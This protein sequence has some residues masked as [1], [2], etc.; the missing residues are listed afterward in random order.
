MNELRREFLKTGG[1]ATAL[2]V[3]VAAGLLQ[4]TRVLALEWNKSAF[5]AKAVPDALKGLGAASPI[6]TKEIF[7]KAPDI[8]ENGAVVPVEVISKLPDTQSIAIFV[9]KNVNPLIADF[10]LAH[11][12]EG[13]VSTR[14]KMSQTSIVRVVVNSGGK[15]YTA[16]KEVKVTIGGCGG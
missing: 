13:F 7:I 5:E 11:G 8:A 3:C 2:A 1:A 6:E 16:S 15:F 10:T 12:A 4:P 14:I 9:E